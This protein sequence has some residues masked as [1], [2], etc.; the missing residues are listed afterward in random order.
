MSSKAPIVR[1]IAWLSVV[2]QLVIMALIMWL[3][4]IAGV[5]QAILLGALTYLALSI[6]LRFG[7]PKAHRRGISL[8]KR[9]QYTE[10]IP[11]FERS[12]DF[13]SRNRWIDDLR[14]LVLLSSS[15]ISYREMALLNLAFCQSQAGNGLKAKECYQ[16]T[17]AEFPDSEMAKASLKMIESAEKAAQPTSRGD[18]STRA[19]AG[20]GTPQK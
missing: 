19:D 3:L 11:E 16:R 17:L 18:S 12:Y 15:R 14:F 20:I 4:S 6:I 9:K 2:P 5:Q 1:Q 7:I 13:F 8:F 10:A